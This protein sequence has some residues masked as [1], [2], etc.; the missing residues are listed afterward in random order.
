MN[1][2]QKVPVAKQSAYSRRE[3][4]HEIERRSLR[5]KEIVNEMILRSYKRKMSVHFVDAVV[6]RA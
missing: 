5:N 3:E 1:A 2:Q 6:P 4:M